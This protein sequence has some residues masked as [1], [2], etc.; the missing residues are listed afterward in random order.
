MK[1][2]YRLK[3]KTFG[4]LGK[5]AGTALQAT[6]SLA[7]SGVGKIGGAALGASVGSKIGGSMGLLGSIIPGANIVGGAI[8]G[9]AGAA[10]G[11][12]IAKR[13]GQALKQTG[14]DLRN[15]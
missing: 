11:S 10:I 7:D 6:G 8:G 12:A 9:L 1:T 15:N 4:L 5:T 14:T 13:T 2:T 3:R